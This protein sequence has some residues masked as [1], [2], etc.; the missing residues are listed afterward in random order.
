[1]IEL[2]FVACLIAEPARCE[3]RALPALIDI[4]EQQCMSV[5]Q[6]FLAA[7]AGR[8]A[9]YRIR[10]WTCREVGAYADL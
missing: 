1:M 2:V 10:S 4:T 7:W 8:N 9:G 3:H 5:S 6:Q